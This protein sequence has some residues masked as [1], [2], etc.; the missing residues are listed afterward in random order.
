MATTPSQQQ[1]TKKICPV[2]DNQFE[3]TDYL[4]HVY[5]EMIKQLMMMNDKLSDISDAVLMTYTYMKDE[6]EHSDGDNGND[7]G[8]GSAELGVD[9]DEDISEGKTAAV[10]LSEAEL[11]MIRRGEMYQMTVSPATVSS[12]STVS[13][14]KPIK[15]KKQVLTDQ[16][17]SDLMNRIIKEEPEKHE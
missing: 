11:E 14:N 16:E 1:T 3:P 12:G 10:D 13:A 17:I 8:K 7:N 2:C 6:E 9:I 5:E 4:F 15:E